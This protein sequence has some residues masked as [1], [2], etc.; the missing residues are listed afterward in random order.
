MQEVPILR[1]W[2]TCRLL[3]CF[4]LSQPTAEAAS[5]GASLVLSQRQLDAYIYTYPVVLLIA[6][7][8]Y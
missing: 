3:A 7:V 6:Q 8:K 5:L 1:C 2:E 4:R